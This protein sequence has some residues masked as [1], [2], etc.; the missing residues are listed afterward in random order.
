MREG[1]SLN[2][3]KQDVSRGYQRVTHMIG[4]ARLKVLLWI[5]DASREGLARIRAASWQILPQGLMRGEWIAIAALLISLV[6][7]YYTYKKVDLS[8]QSLKQHLDPEIPCL[9]E[10]PHD[11]F[12]VFIL[13]NEGPIDAESLSVNHLTFIY[14]KT[15]Q[16]GGMGFEPSLGQ[17]PGF[18][19]LYEPILERN[20]RISKKIFWGAPPDDKGIIFVLIFDVSYHRPT[21]GRLYQKRC[22]FYRD[23]DHYETRTSFRL[24]PHFAAVNEQIERFSEKTYGWIT[25][26]PDRLRE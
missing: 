4:P 14:T 24:N 1:Y 8:S 26:G 21:D 18:R 2:R 16:K 17:R 20:K 15:L 12:P 5:F 10:N 23:G 6:N 13:L 11:R 25:Q 9:L 3:F 19:W 7:A 22:L